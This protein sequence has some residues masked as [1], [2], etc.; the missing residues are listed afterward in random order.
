MDIENGQP[1]KEPG[2]VMEDVRGTGAH[3][4]RDFVDPAG[5]RYDP[6]TQKE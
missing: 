4:V 6:Q 1:E 5:D 3:S 2:G